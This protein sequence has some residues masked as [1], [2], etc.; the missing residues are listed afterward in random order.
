LQSLLVF[1]YSNTTTCFL[2]LLRDKIDNS[3]K[4]GVDLFMKTNLKKI[5]Y[6]A[7]VTLTFT[8]TALVVL[9]IGTYLDSGIT[10]YFF[11]NYRTSFADPM[12]YFRLF[13]HILGHANWEHFY[14]NFLLIL[15]LG[16]ILEE[17]YGSKKL[18]QMILF[19]AFITGLINTLF[20]DTAILGASGIVFMI[21]LLSSYANAQAGKI[22]LTLIIVV[23]IFLGKEVVTGLTVA[24]NISQLTHIFGGLCG[25]V[26]GFII[27]KRRR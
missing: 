18:L 13:S 1:Q 5:Q 15:L 4:K 17:K 21:I 19:T 20:F 10:I 25:G 8:F 27:T 11:S 24:D 6:N 7:P 3:H 22:P 14:S 23:I 26:F 2:I 16:P 12:Q 9:L